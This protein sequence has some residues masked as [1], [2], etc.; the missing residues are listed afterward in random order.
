MNGDT[1]KILSRLT[2]IDI[3]LA[4]MTQQIQNNHKA[5]RDSENRTE[6]LHNKII[7]TLYGNG[8]PGLTTNVETNFQSMKQLNAIFKSHES[9]DVK[10]MGIMITILLAILGKL[11]WPT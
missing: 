2:S 9:R 5:F 7:E 11:F 6:N 1:E 8:K 10:W 3:A 4:T